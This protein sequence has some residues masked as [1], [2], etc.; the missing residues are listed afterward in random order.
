MA[1]F[2]YVVLSASPGELMLEQNRAVRNAVAEQEMFFAD[3]HVKKVYADIDSIPDFWKWLSGPFLSTVLRAD[4]PDAPGTFYKY[5]RILGGVRLRQVPSR[6]LLLLLRLAVC[7]TVRDHCAVAAGAGASE[8][9]L[10]AHADAGLR[11][12]LLPSLRQ[13]A[14]REGVVRPERHR[15]QPRVAVVLRGRER[16]GEL[17]R[18]Y[19]GL[20][21]GVGLHA[22]A[23][24]RPRR[25]AGTRAL[26]STPISSAA[27][28]ERFAPRKR[29]GGVRERRPAS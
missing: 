18:P 20:V 4:F 17:H 23:P 19:V 24:T 6:A 21:P 11:T 25:G 27:R 12:G 16:G 13:K 9:L 8:R 22:H 28:A 2:T 29:R 7:I 5:F 15:R 14:R 3:Y 1:L 10:G 26:W